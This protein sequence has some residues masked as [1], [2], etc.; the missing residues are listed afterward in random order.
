MCHVTTSMIMPYQ[1]WLIPD[2][3]RFLARRIG[4]RTSYAPSLR[5]MNCRPV[6]MS[7]HF[8][9]FFPAPLSKTSPSRGKHSLQPM[10]TNRLPCASSVAALC[11]ML[12][13]SALQQ[14]SQQILK[15]NTAGRSCNLLA[16]DKAAS[17][18]AVANRSRSQTNRCELGRMC[19]WMLCARSIEGHRNMY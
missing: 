18:S 4:M 17:I 14:S 13:I 11:C 3:L 5:T 16:R 1:Q 2:R 6:C 8:S 19:A 15:I 12:A 9:P 7:D 10:Y